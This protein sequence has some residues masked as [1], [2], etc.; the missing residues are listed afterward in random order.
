MR[1]IS[2]ASRYSLVLSF[3][4]LFAAAAL[5]QSN[6]EQTA[7]PHDGQHG[8]DF[9]I[10]TWK[11]HLKRLLNPLTGSHQW[12]EFDGTSYTQKVWGGRANIEQ[13]ET[14]G[15]AG[16]IEG[17][18]LRLY[19]PESRQ[20][21]L[22][23]GTSKTGS[24]VIPTI[25]EFKNG[26]GEFYDQE[27]YKGRTILVRFIWSRITDNSAHFEQSFSDDGGKTW[28]VNWITD[29]TRIS[30][31]EF[32]AQAESSTPKPDAQSQDG[33]HD[34]DFEIGSWKAHL[35]RR[36]HPLTGSD[37]WVEYDGTS[38]V[39]KLWNGRANFGELEVGNSDTHIEGL[40]LRLFNPQSHQWRLYW[41]NS[42]DGVL[43][44]PA[45][46]QY[47]NGRG[48]FFDQ[49]DFNDKSIFV[50]FVFS[51]VSANSF[52]TEQSFSPDFGKTWEPNWIGTF[53]RPKE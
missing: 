2:R 48:E 39:K 32:K 50:R 49:E 40:T 13:F 47:T 36:Q 25:G 24:L 7:D 28:E 11:I 9:E 17:L 43:S 38:V 10:G 4:V 31:D 51:D 45:I 30:A 52:Q 18:T 20:W 23:W 29:Q 27:A 14:T 15:S 41:A 3:I 19:N 21:S 33:Q 42:K 53:T 22:Y 35:K 16:H 12:V 1:P 44:P 26:Q 8:F 5:A 46:G 37:Q 34:F 6:V